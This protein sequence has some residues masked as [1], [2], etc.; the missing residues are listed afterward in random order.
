MSSITR[1]QRSANYQQVQNREPIVVCVSN[2][3]DC[4]TVGK[5]KVVGGA[6]K[7]IAVTPAK[8]GWARMQGG[9]AKT[10]SDLTYSVKAIRYI[11][12]Y[13]VEVAVDK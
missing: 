13:R 4:Y 6:P 5:R 11:I 3:F 2:D 8:N 10:A 7:L 1:L 9:E 12:R